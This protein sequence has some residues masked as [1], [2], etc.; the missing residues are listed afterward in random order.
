MSISIRR[1]QVEDLMAMQAANLTCL[2]ENYQMKYYLYHILSWP[3]LSFV[4]EDHKGKIVGYVLAKMD[5]EEQGEPHGH[6]TSLA[7]MRSYRKLGL[8]TRLMNQSQKAMVESFDAYYVSLHVRVGNRAALKLYKDT[9]QFKIHDVEAKYYADH[10]DAYGMRK[11]LKEPKKKE[12][13]VKQIAGGKAEE[14]QPK[15]K[16]LALEEAKKDNKQEI[17]EGAAGAPSTT[18]GAAPKKKKKKPK[19]K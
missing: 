1:A 2:P 5:E 7:V 6:I 9:L 16:V 4:A 17:E 18:S 19:K 13:A 14:T 12:T 11:E 8:A 3:Q 10:E 15:K